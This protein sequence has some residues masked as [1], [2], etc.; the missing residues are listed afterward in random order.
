MISSGSVSRSRKIILRI[1]RSLRVAISRTHFDDLATASARAGPPPPAPIRSEAI[2]AALQPAHHV[3]VVRR[4]SRP[5]NL[6]AIDF[7]SVFRS[8]AQ[9]AGQPVVPE[10]DVTVRNSIH[11][12]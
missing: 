6:V 10:S 5:L 7:R 2:G 1:V 9:D 4:R 12:Q 8:I 11:G 3:A